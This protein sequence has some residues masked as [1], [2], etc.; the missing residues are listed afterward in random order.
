HDFN[1]I[2]AAI[3]G[4]V[5]LA[6]DEI[7]EESRAGRRLKRVRTAALRGRDIVQQL[8]TFSRKTEQEK[9]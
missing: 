9:K 7:S 2:L 3:I 5:E 8:L 1:N 4:F 6:Q